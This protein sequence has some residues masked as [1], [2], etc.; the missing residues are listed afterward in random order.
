MVAVGNGNRHINDNVDLFISAIRSFQKC[1]ASVLR[2][3][4][5]GRGH[6]DRF[7]IMED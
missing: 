3:N 4:T 5:D 2:K 7:V 6:I 1:P